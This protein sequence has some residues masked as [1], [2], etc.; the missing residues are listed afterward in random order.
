MGV[1]GDAVPQVGPV[2]WP[3]DRK[4]AAVSARHLLEAEGEAGVHQE[5]LGGV[6]PARRH[7]VIGLPPA[8]APVEAGRGRAVGNQT[9]QVAALV[10]DDAGDRLGEAVHGVL[11]HLPPRQLL[12]GGGA[13]VEAGRRHHGVERVLADRGAAARGHQGIEARL[14]LGVSA[15]EVVEGLG[16]DAEDGAAPALVLALVQVVDVHGG[17]AQERRAQ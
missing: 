11:D 15:P 12:R 9:E 8:G 17:G 13:G 16:K 10:G 2:E 14:K 7:V 5:V 4:R 6:G 3:E 1:E